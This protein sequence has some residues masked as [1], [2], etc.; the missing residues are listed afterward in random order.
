VANG[1]ETACQYY[2]IASATKQS[3]QLASAG[4]LPPARKN[5]SADSTP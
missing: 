3:S 2:V 5:A 4:L 1:R